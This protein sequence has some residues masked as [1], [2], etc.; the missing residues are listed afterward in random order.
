MLLC[1]A[2]Q[3]CT[4]DA[5]EGT[6]LSVSA[7]LLQ[8]PRSPMAMLRSP[9]LHIQRVSSSANNADAKDDS[10]P[11]VK[12][13]AGLAN[14]AL[15]PS[16]YAAYA[17]DD[18]EQE[19]VIGK[20]AFGLVTLMRCKE[21][22]QLVAMKTIDR[23][24]LTTIH[25]KKAVAREIEILKTVVPRHEGIVP[26][27]QLIETPRSIHMVMEYASGGTL[28]DCLAVRGGG[29]LGEARARR[30]AAQLVAAVAHLHAHRVCHRDLKLENCV[31]D[32]DGDRGRHAAASG[33]GR[34]RVRLIDFGLSYRW[35]EGEQQK[36]LTK[37]A[38]SLH[39]MAPEMLARTGY[40]GAHID[41]W[42]LGVILAAMLTGRLLF[43]ADTEKALKAAVLAGTYELP[44]RRTD[45]PV[46]EQSADLVRGF[47]TL[48]PQTRLSVAD[49]R[50]HE[51]LRGEMGHAE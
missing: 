50:G 19:S 38:G 23:F 35:A 29:A 25:L 24:R 43:R 11:V 36:P 37:L 10:T 17:G 41:A 8:R 48:D 6:D 34:E 12:K 7:L 45:P 44:D 42:S 47:L 15:T 32:D 16:R 13:K 5:G 31:L 46:S 49:A 27:L 26:L 2:V 3:A 39:Y 51:W 21:S 9:L 30:L 40:L 14:V 18:Y 22:E 20:G 33:G 28:F 4:E 1:G